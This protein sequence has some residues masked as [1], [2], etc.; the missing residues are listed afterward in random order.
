MSS[1]TRTVAQAHVGLTAMRL[2]TMRLTTT[3]MAGPWR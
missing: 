3:G 2:T 1:G